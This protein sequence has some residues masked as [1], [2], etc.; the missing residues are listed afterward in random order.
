MVE[1]EEE[2]LL[3]GNGPPH[4]GGGTQIFHLCIINLVIGTLY[5]AKGNYEFGIS[6]IMKALEP[7]D[8]KLGMDTWFYCKRCFLA[9]AEGIAK[10]TIVIKDDLFDEMMVFLD[11]VSKHGQQVTVAVPQTKTNPDG[12]VVTLQPRTV[13]QE[14]RIL[15]RLFI[16]L[17]E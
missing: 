11:D 14:A 7:Y 9:L 5:C 12:S 8:R 16:V 2:K 15:K 10:Q 13:T 17:H 4:L 1:K 3:S 6:R